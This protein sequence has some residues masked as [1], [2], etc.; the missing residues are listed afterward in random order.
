MVGDDDVDAEFV[1]AGD[2]GSGAD[3]GVDADDELD[4]V[5]GGGLDLPGCMP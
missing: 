3:A 2:D 4:A 1:G 5:G